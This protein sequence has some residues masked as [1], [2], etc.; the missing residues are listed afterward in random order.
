MSLKECPL[1]A[2]K[3]KTFKFALAF[4]GV[5]CTSCMLVLKDMNT[6]EA[7]AIKQWGSRITPEEK[8]KR[9]GKAEMS[10]LPVGI[11]EVVVH[12]RDGAGG[13]FSWPSTDRLESHSIRNYGLYDTVLDQAVNLALTSKQPEPTEW[14]KLQPKLLSDLDD[15][16]YSDYIKLRRSSRRDPQYYLRFIPETKET[17]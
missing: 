14:E 1:C 8:T 7:G 15:N 6:S 16:S 13:R 3:A 4:W 9:K 10:T 5:K 11:F 2:S 12:D 17:V